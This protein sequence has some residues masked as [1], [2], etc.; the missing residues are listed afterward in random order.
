MLVG[1]KHELAW[2]FIIDLIFAWLG[3]QTLVKPKLS[4][5][6]AKLDFLTKKRRGRKPSNHVKAAKGTEKQLH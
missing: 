1:T 2:W 6:F 3:V 5:L 4:F